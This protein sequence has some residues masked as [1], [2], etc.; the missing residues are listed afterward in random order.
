MTS[1]E[2]LHTLPIVV[3]PSIDV[4]RHSDGYPTHV[5]WWRVERPKGAVLYL[6]GIQ[7]H[8]GWYETSGA[9][10]AELGYTVLMPDRRGSGLNQRD[11]GHAESAER[12]IDDV[13][14]LLDALLAETDQAGAHIVGVSWG[15]KHAAAATP[16]MARWVKSLSLIAPGIFPRIDLPT[17]E[18]FRVAFSLANHRKRMFDVPLNDPRLFTGNPDRIRYVDQDPLR[19]MEVSAT[20]LVASRRLDRLARKLAESTWRGSVHLLLAGRDR[21]I[22]NDKTSEWLRGLPSP[23]RQITQYPD[24]HHTLEFESDPSAFHR[25]LCEWIDRRGAAGPVR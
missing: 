22:E 17:M 1:S 9:K 14:E 4:F 20:F 19:L 5:R 18:K 7:S 13:R 21:I 8:G 11:R 12:L 15:G 24:A 3:Q 25:D 23:D 2:V 6:H 10:L 16:A